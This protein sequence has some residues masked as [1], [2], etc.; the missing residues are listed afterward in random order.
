MTFR[1]PEC[2]T[3]SATSAKEMEGSRSAE[4]AYLLLTLLVYATWTSIPNIRCEWDRP[5]SSHVCYL[6][7]RFCISTHSHLRNRSG[8]ILSSTSH[9]NTQ[10][11]LPEQHSPTLLIDACSFVYSPL[12]AVLPLSPSFPKTNKQ[13][14][15]IF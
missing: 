13:T 11:E 6:L 4:L 3:I 2:L 14:K 1:L 12:Q 5:I 7:H 10:E 8:F 15:E 9:Y